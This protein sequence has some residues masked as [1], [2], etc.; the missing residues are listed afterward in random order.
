MKERLVGTQIGRWLSAARDIVSLI[1]TPRVALGT[2]VNDQLAP[3]LLAQLC[4]PNEV[5][6][7]VGAHIGS[8]IAEV[9]HYCPSAR[10]VAFEAMPDKVAWL[11]RKFPTVTIHSCALSDQSGEAEFF[12]NLSQSG[13][14]SLAEQKGSVRRITV[15]MK[16]M[17]D[18]LDQADL[19]KIDV[20]GAELGVLRGAARLIE[21]CQPL[22][23]F[24]SG[25]GNVLGFTKEDIFSFFSDRGYGL[26]APNR[27]AH[28]GGVMTLDAF[29]DSHQYPRRTTNYFAV[30]ITRLN[31][32]RARAASIPH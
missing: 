21:K 2:T 5:F 23:M 15:A 29:L 7:D 16:R 27:L 17:D 19:I 14:S 30:P 9:R 10:I 32:F 6:V 3:R 22:I 11:I 20:E 25:P 4:R 1:R 12:V 31:E 26:L 18:L 24:E 13:Y 28:T 8:V